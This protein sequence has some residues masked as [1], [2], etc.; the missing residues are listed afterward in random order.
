MNVYSYQALEMIVMQIAAHKKHQ[1]LSDC[2]A[3]RHIA[4]GESR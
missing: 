1:H 3:S 4:Q 2:Q